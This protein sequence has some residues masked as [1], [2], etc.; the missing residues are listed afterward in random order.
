MIEYLNTPPDQATLKE[1]LKLFRLGPR[2]TMR[3]NEA[4]YKEAELDNEGL[5]DDQLI[6]TMISNPILI[7]R[8]IVLANG[9]AVIGR[10]PENVLDII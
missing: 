8:P 6:A 2:D 7:Q 9:K 3:K 1:I 10:P 4:V 5:D